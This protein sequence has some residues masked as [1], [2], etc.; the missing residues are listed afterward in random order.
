VDIKRVYKP[1]LVELSYFQT[2]RLFYFDRMIKRILNVEGD[3]VE[4]GVGHGR[5]LLMLALLIKS[6]GI[7]KKIW[8]FDSFEGFPEPT[9]EDKS[10]RNSKKGEW[11]DT[12][13]QKVLELLYDSGLDFNFVGSNI[14]LVK[15]FVKDTLRTFSGKISLLHIDLDLYDGY[16]STL[17]QLYPRMSKHGIII[18]DEYMTTTE[19][20]KFPGAQKA[21]SEFFGEDKHKIKYDSITG[22]YYY[23]VS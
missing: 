4:C 3:I 21:I 15:G 13:I 14:V 10:I 19:Y 9:E 18:F 23:V 7:Q 17:E 16:K 8:G 6:N 2:S 1:K 11:G 5:S 20:K 12:S 22:K